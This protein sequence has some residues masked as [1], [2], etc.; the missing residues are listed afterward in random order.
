MKTATDNIF[1]RIKDLGEGA[2]FTPKDFLDVAERGMV[3]V[4]LKKLLEQGLVRRLVRGLY[5]LP[6]QM[7]FSRLNSVPT[8]MQWRRPS[9]PIS[10]ANRPQRGACRE[11]ARA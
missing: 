5:D 9:P 10:L 3:D 7:L 6:K 11:H 2:V 4:T 8:L 1:M